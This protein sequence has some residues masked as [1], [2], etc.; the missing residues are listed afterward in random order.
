MIPLGGISAVT[1]CFFVPFVLQGFP[2]SWITL[3]G[4]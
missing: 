1:V 2:L 3:R 4:G